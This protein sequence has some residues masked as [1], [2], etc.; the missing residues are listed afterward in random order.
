MI[1]ATA[2]MMANA[3]AFSNR[4]ASGRFTDA[5]GSAVGLG[6]AHGRLVGSMFALLLIDASIIGACAVTLATSYAFGDAFGDAQ[7]A[8]SAGAPP[9]ALSARERESWRMPPVAL[10]NRPVWSPARKLAVLSMQA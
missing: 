4:P 10:L 2:I 8:A 9:L 1:G 6:A 3:A 7:P 5:L